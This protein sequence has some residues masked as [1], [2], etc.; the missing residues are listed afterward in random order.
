MLNLSEIRLHSSQ[1]INNTLLVESSIQFLV[2]STKLNVY[3]IMLLT[4]VSLI[5]NLITVFVFSQKRF[6]VNSSNVYILALA[7]N[8]TLFLVVH[9]FQSTVSKYSLVYQSD[10]SYVSQLVKSLNIVDRF[11]FACCVFNFLNNVLTMLS[12]CIVISSLRLSILTLKFFLYFVS[13]QKSIY[14]PATFDC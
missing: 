4:A 14:Y 13:L 12:V 10:M 5:G 6:R 1:P 7:V 9:F 3:S 11:D 8:H 2:N